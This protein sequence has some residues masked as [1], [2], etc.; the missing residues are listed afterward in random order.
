MKDQ[1]LSPKQKIYSDKLQKNH[2]KSIKHDE[3]LIFLIK[4]QILAIDK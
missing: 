3:E 2:P 4:F 1:L